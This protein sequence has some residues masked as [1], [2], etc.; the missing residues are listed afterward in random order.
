MMT[1]A[2]PGGLSQ[3]SAWCSD[4]RMAQRAPFT[5]GG[6]DLNANAHRGLV[7]THMLIPPAL[8]FSPGRIQGVV[9]V[10]EHRMGGTL[11]I[12]KPEATA[13]R[14]GGGTQRTGRDGRGPAGARGGGVG[15]GHDGTAS[16]W[17]NHGP[18]A[19]S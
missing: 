7:G 17:G 4:S 16:Q 8:G 6:A 5:A 2:K 3:S 11:L 1:E 9:E 10:I 13:D 18:C 15:N 19:R 14:A 12:D